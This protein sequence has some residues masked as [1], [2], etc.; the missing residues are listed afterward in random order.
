MNVENVRVR[1]APSPTGHLHV[2]GL[3]TALFNWLF[4][5]HYKG[6][7]LL[8]VEDTDQERSKLEYMHSQL[9]SLAWVGITSDEV[10]L[11]QSERFAIYTEI[12]Q[13][14]LSQNK[15]YRCDC[16]AEQVQ[17]RLAAAGI[18][19]QYYGYDGFCR[20]RTIAQDQQAAIRFALPDDVTDITFNDLIRGTVTVTKNEL[21]DFVIVRSDGTPMYNFVVV[22]DDFFSKITHIIR[23]EDHISNTPKQILLYQACGYPLPIFA[24]IPMILGSDGN[25]LSKRDGAVDVLA[26]RALGY[27]PDALLNYIVRLGWSHGD[28]EVFT[29]SELVEHFTLQAIGKKPAIF[30]YSKL[31]WM[32]GV[33]MRNRSSEN[34][35]TVMQ[36]LDDAWRSK[37]SQWSE[38]DLIKL[39]SL[40]K[41]RTTMVVQLADVLLALSKAPEIYVQDDLSKWMTVESTMLLSSL[42]ETLEVAD[43]SLEAIQDVIKNFC[44]ERDIKLVTVAQPLRIALTGGAN[45]PGI[46]ELLVLVGK[47]ESIARIGT[48]LA[49]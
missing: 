45:S 36:E 24:H 4:A 14:L 49:L 2:G 21:A 26:Y 40:Y 33:Y 41:E 8:R 1:F 9:A 19:D 28:Q 30:D 42:L 37:V 27:L 10:P 23:G 3:R 22:I 25:R 34:L 46:F 7:F 35:L 15:A 17:A 39:I 47:Q 6:T 43:W 32:N 13:S 18:T 11:I 38:I 29:Q 48:L 20:A 16:T 44:K 31:E 12:A 5:K